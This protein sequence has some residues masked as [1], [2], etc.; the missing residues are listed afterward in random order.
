MLRPL[1]LSFSYR[2]ICALAAE[3]AML[4]A[5]AISIVRSNFFMAWS[6]QS[7]GTKKYRFNTRSASGRACQE[8]PD[9]DGAGLVGVQRKAQSFETACG[10]FRGPLLWPRGRQAVAPG[11]HTVGFDFAYDGPGAGKGGTGVLKVD[12]AEVGTMKMP[13]TI[14]FAWPFYE[15]FDVGVD[16]RTSVNE[17]DYQVPFG[18]NGKIEKLTFK[19]E[20]DLLMPANRGT[21]QK[22]NATAHG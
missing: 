12:G 16:T 10:M 13:Q 7:K 21:M 4:Q 18:F 8:I 20:R 19:L 5:K 14:P 6:G 17:A 15:S 3:A 22:A 9:T 11:K 1:K 2:T